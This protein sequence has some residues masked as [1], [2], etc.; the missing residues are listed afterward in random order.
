MRPESTL[1]FSGRLVLLIR[2]ELANELWTRSTTLPST[3][4]GDQCSLGYKVL[5]D[6]VVA[7]SR[8]LRLLSTKAMARTL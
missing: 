3:V 4:C 5:T 1:L 2:D 6:P 8:K 7:F